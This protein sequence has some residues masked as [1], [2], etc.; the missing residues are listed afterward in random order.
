M[1]RY[2]PWPGVVV[3]DPSED[4]K[5]KAPKQKNVKCIFFFGA[6]NL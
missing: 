3:N 5:K 4:L 2:S 1:K 6:K